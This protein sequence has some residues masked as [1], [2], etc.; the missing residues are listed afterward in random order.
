MPASLAAPEY[1]QELRD[2][3]PRLG[4]TA[5]EERHLRWRD[6]FAS[7]PRGQSQFKDLLYRRGRIAAVE[8]EVAV[9]LTPEGIEKQ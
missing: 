6:R 2:T 3:Q 8:A 9:E 7:T 4:A 1:I 5:S